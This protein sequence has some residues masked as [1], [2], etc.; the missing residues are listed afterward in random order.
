V[1]RDLD[2]V[3]IVG[4]LADDDRRQVLAALILGDS[5]LD[6]VARTTALSTTAAAKAL[7]RLADAGLVIHGSEGGLHLVAE[8]FRVAARTARER[9]SAVVGDEHAG[10]PDDAKKVMRAFVRDGRILQIPTTLS[11]RIVLMDWLA[12]DFELGRRYTEQQVNLVLAKRHPDTA[13]WRRYLVDNDFLDRVGG[14][15]WRSGGSVPTG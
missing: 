12:Q 4:L 5:T 8:A 10:V 6:E 3:T 13:A 11:K 9:E 1:S 7:G 15:Y 2:A 14:E